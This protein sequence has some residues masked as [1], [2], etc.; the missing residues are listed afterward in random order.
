MALSITVLLPAEVVVVALKGETDNQ[1][2]D[3]TTK[4]VVA[5]WLLAFLTKTSKFPGVTKRTG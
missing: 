3:V 1:P 5:L 2:D 4:V